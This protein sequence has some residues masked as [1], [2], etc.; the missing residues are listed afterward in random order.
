[1]GICGASTRHGYMWY[2]YYH[3][4]IWHVYLWDEWTW[5]SNKTRIWIS[6]KT[7]FCHTSESIWVKLAKSNVSFAQLQLDSHSCFTFVFENPS[8]CR[9]LPVNWRQWAFHVCHDPTSDRERQA[10]Q[11]F[12]TQCTIVMCCCRHKHVRVFTCCIWFI[13][14]PLIGVAHVFE[15]FLCVHV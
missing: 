7:R 1:M 10:Q 8:P 3:E 9:N 5:A 2:Q 15:G 14:F 13:K 11:H 4:Y 6:V 12:N